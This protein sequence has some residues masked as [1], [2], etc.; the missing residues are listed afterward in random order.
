MPKIQVKI[1]LTSDAAE[2]QDLRPRLTALALESGLD[3][4]ADPFANAVTEALNNCVEHA[5]GDVRGRPIELT[6]T[7]DAH[8]VRAALRDWGK[9][10]ERLPLGTCPDPLSMPDGGW[11]WF[12]I[13]SCTDEVLYSNGPDG[14]LLTL[15]KRLP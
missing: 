4:A 10:M 5:Y 11:G 7:A 6:W 9:S 2:V 14:N 15:V 12:I 1:A 3:S 8:G 13:R